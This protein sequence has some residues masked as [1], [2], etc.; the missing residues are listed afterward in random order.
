M[1]TK[2]LIFSFIKASTDGVTY[3]DMQGLGFCRATMRRWVI[4]LERDGVVERTRKHQRA[5][6]VFSAVGDVTNI[7]P[8]T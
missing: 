2:E 1:S 3:A 6:A 7:T 8:S 5:R 4:E